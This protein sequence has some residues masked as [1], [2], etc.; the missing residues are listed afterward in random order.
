[1]A[2]WA[3]LN[4]V[5]SLPSAFCTVYCDDV[6]PAFWNDSFRYG[7][8]NSTYRVDD[9]VS[10]RITAMLP[11]PLATRGLSVAMAENVLLIWLSDSCGTAALELPPA[12][13]LGE[14][15]P[16]AAMTR[17]AL[18]ATAVSATF[19]V[20]E[21]KGTTSLWAGTC[22]GYAAQRFSMNRHTPRSIWENSKTVGMNRGVNI[23][24]T[25]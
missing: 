19:L 7:A 4:W 9:T 16:Q 5:A 21:C 6:S 24:A 20:T 22:Q 8:S 10:G 17:A 11:L 13:L 23:S 15:L 12:E 3:S 2:V 14:L 1:M 25:S 18:P